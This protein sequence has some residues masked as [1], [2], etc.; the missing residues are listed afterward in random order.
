MI[1]KPLNAKEVAQVYHAQ[2][3][4]AFPPAELKPLSAI[5]TMMTQGVYLPYGLMDGGDIA[6]LCFLWK[7]AHNWL[8][9]DYLSVEKSRRN[10]KLGAVI[11]SQMQGL[12]PHATIIAESEYP[13][14]APDPAMAERRLGFYRR[15]R[16]KE[17]KVRGNLFGVCYSIL[18]WG[19][20]VDEKMLTAQYRGIYQGSFSPEKFATYVRIPD[21]SHAPS[22]QIPWEQ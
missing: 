10:Q 9:L 22:P 11:L 3:Q 12:F 14:F 5:Q 20:S 8:L 17:V 18:Y 16:A 1:L 21:E 7:G 19:D 2:M 4:E 13:P 6:G 15:N